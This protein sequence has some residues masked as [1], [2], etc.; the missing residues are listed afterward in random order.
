VLSDPVQGRFDRSK[1][2]KVR[3]CLLDRA[4]AATDSSG[5]CVISELTDNHVSNQLMLGQY[6]IRRHCVFSRAT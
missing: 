6:K 5:D 4:G 2:S 1:A 3:S